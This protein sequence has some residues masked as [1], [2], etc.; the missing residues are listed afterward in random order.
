MS[1]AL[2]LALTLLE[3]GSAT[4]MAVTAAP[5]K[6]RTRI[7]VVFKQETGSGNRQAKTESSTLG[8]ERTSPFAHSMGTTISL[9]RTMLSRLR[10]ADSIV[11]GSLLS[12]STSSRND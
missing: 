3:E 10:A 12:C 1:T 4:A 11:R 6:G 7:R 9:A 2:M 8:C 5:E